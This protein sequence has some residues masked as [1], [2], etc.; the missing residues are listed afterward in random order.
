MV[1]DSKKCQTLINTAAEKVQELKVIATRLKA[2]RTAYQTQGVDPTGTAL[3]GNV[4]EVSVWIDD[5]D[6]VADNAAANGLISAVVPSHRSTAL[7][8]L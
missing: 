2:C 3:E 4:A 1:A 6:A 7:G 8:A 5:V